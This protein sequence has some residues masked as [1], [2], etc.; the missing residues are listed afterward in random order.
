MWYD[1]KALTSELTGMFFYVTPYMGQGTGSHNM[2]IPTLLF[3]IINNTNNTT[4]KTDTQ[5]ELS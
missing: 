4:V 3:P 5:D 1:L 2:D